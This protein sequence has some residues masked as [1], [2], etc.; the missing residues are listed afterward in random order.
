MHSNPNM[1]G[2]KPRILLAGSMGAY[3]LKYCWLLE[4]EDI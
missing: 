1:G 2:L 4:K 3:K